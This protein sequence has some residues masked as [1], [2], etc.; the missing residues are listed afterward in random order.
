MISAL[1]VSPANIH[2]CGEGTPEALDVFLCATG[3]ETRARFIAER[4]AP[5]ARSRLAVG[6]PDQRVLARDENDRWFKAAGY[7]LE[8]PLDDSFQPFLARE[9]TSRLN[10]EGKS[11]CRI[12]VD[13]SCFS[14]KRIAAIVD[15]CRRLT[16]ESF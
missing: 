12:G 4:L 14:R 2:L 6:F 9:L 8:V 16:H 11:R 15:V 10:L 3:Y 7:D 1:R 13:V 5:S